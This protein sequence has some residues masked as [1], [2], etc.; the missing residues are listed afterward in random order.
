VRDDVIHLSCE[1]INTSL[2]AVCAEGMPLE[3]R[4]ASLLPLVAIE[5]MLICSITI[6]MPGRDPDRWLVCAWSSWHE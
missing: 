4:Q 2:S 1:L 5:A 3:V 6:A